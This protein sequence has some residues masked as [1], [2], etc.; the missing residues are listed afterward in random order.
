ML[1]FVC[2]N[3]PIPFYSHGC[4][5]RTYSILHSSWLQHKFR[6]LPLCT[7][8]MPSAVMTH[9]CINSFVLMPV[10][11]L[12]MR[13]GMWAC[14]FHN[15]NLGC[16]GWDAHCRYVLLL[17]QCACIFMC[18]IYVFLLD[19]LMCQGLTFFF[20]FLLYVLFMCH[21]CSLRIQSFYV[22]LKFALLG[23]THC[24]FSILCSRI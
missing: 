23:C 13:S 22:H 21:M 18:H 14:V 4:L 1:S 3:L 16:E 5:K 15:G 17:Q 24:N 8:H 12:N 2:M 7:L 20:F 6:L 11:L 10:G 19:S 9:S